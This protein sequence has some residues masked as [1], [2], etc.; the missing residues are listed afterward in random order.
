[1]WIVVAVIT[2]GTWLFFFTRAR[3]LARTIDRGEVIV[4]KP[5]GVTYL[6]L[7]VAFA[8]SGAWLLASCST[9]AWLLNG[10]IGASLHRTRSFG[11]LAQD[12]T[13][14][15]QRGPR[16]AVSH[17][18][19]YQLARVLMRAAAILGFL[20]ATLLLRYSLRWYVAFPAALL[21]A[22]LFI[23]ISAFVVAYQ[24]KKA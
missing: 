10:A 2:V 22:Y 18:E 6:A 12:T 21:S 4:L 15:M 8:V 16:L 23:G 3:P 19:S 20:L 14:Y 17:A 11:E 9:V 5:L 24:R 7:F 13:Q 1:M